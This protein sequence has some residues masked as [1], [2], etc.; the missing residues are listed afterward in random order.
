[1]KEEIAQEI[2]QLIKLKGYRVKNNDVQTFLQNFIEKFDRI[3]MKNEFDSVVKGY[4]I[5]KNEDYLLE[6]VKTPNK[7][8]PLIENKESVL[9]LIDDKTNSS[10]YN[11][12]IDIF[13]DS[14]GRR[15]C[16]SCGEETSIHETID[17]IIIILDYPRIYGKKKYCGLC[18]YEW[19]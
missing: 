11:N 10:S 7:S 14:I 9:D 3:P 4:I 16:S 18:S 13:E 19:K 15:K 2:N 17:K 6:K 5:M 8:E 12:N 1:M